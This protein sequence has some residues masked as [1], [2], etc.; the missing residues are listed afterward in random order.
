M[1]E[2]TGWVIPILVKD[3]PIRW[4]FFCSGTWVHLVDSTENG[5]I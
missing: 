2:K 5:E 1:L 3:K 4:D